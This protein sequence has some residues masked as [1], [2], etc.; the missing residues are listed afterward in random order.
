[1]LVVED[2]EGCYVP[3]IGWCRWAEVL[4]DG[5]AGRLLVYLCGESMVTE[6]L[7]ESNPAV[8]VLQRESV[9]HDRPD[10][11]RV[12]PT[13]QP[14]LAVREIPMRIRPCSPDCSR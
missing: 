2:L 11:T 8:C 4:C 12:G 3:L 7:E 1:M 9:R 13:Q 10:R 5:G 14:S 6:P